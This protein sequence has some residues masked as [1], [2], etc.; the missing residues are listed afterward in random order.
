MD[1]TKCKSL[2]EAWAGEPCL[3]VWPLG[4]NGSNRQYCR[5]IGC[6]YSCIGSE[7]PDVRENEAFFY[8]SRFFSEK[9]LRV[10]KVWAVSEDRCCYLQ[11]D[12]GDETLFD[13]LQSC[14][15]KGEMSGVE[16]M[17]ERV[18]SDLVDIQLAGRDAD[19]SMSYPREAFDRQSM[20]WDLNYFKY[21]F[22]KLSYIP[23]DEQL[24]EK[25]FA[26][27]EDFL[28]EEDCGYFLY[29]DFQS[30][31]VMLNNGEPYYI[32]F[33]GGRRGAA[34]YDVASLLYSAK[35]DLSEDQR[36]R[37]LHY[38]IGR[39]ME[40]RSVDP[41]A[42][43]QK[44]YGYVMLRILQAMGAY[45]YRGLYERKGYFMN[46]VSLAARN[47]IHISQQHPL[48]IA[49]PHLTE[50]VRAIFDKYGKEKSAEASRLVVEV[51]S[52]SYRKGYPCD[53]SGNGG[54]FVFDCRALHN[55]GRYEAYKLLTG[56][57]EEV[58]EF[59]KKERAVDEFLANA[60][61]LVRQSVD[62]YIE[63]DFEHLSVY[64]GCT[65]GQHRSVYCAENMAQ[66]LRAEYPNIQ[67]EL[68]HRESD[69]WPKNVVRDCA[70]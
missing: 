2:F 18:L 36:E 60:Q 42:F 37:L 68:H 8:Y 41:K 22:L 50:V 10:P 28:E 63:R 16:P 15:N 34:Q 53:E 17:L 19:F 5:L 55:P 70:K 39:L 14:R 56:R 62:K 26:L 64:F 46:S 44:F 58:R 40:R 61:L 9:G 51:G 12:L 21:C 3:E 27:L 67:V 24:L 38:Y 33:Q 65:G 59:L 6:N 25:D 57:S 29:R 69:S 32:D 43:E 20:Q 7:N 30:R 49:L 48:P 1:T 31:N 52:F 45:G 23:F 13:W 11:E 54:G 66:W 4:A 47:L 35:T